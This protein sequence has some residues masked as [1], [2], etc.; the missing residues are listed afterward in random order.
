MQ[1]SS[2]RRNG[3]FRKFYRLRAKYVSSGNV[4][5]YT[6]IYMS[7]EYRCTDDD[8]LQQD[9]QFTEK[10]HKW[11]FLHAMVLTL[12]HIYRNSH[13]RIHNLSSSSEAGTPASVLIPR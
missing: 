7:I 12:P 10:C 8:M 2:E 6:Y 5:T 11:E 1:T 9:E 4:Y 13:V 3:T